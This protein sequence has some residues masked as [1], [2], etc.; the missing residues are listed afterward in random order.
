SDSTAC[1]PPRSTAAAAPRPRRPRRSSRRHLHAVDDARPDVDPVHGEPQC[2][3][4]GTLPPGLLLA[5]VRQ[6]V[7]ADQRVVL[8]PQRRRC[9]P[10]GGLPAR[11]GDRAVT[12]T[13]PAPVPPPRREQQP[14]QRREEG[15]GGF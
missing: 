15:G 14:Q 13:G 1:P 4:P 5:L 2:A 11:G 8:A 9:R 6:E 10:A 7:R 12:R 3:A